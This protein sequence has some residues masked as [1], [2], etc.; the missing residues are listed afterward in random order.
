MNHGHFAAGHGIE[1]DNS[2]IIKIARFAMKLK[3]YGLVL[4]L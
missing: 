1:A 3:K 4:Q 2:F